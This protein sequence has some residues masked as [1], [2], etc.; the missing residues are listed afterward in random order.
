MNATEEDE[1]RAATL[2]GPSPYRLA[3][4]WGECDPFQIVFSPNYF[5]WF[6]EAT[7]HFFASAGLDRDALRRRHGF[8][9]FPLVK[10]GI[11]FHAPCAAGDR[12]A[13]HSEIVRWGESSFELCHRVLK[14]DG[15]LASEGRE[16]RVWTVS[17]SDGPPISGRIPDEV[18]ARL[19]GSRGER[20]S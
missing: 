11:E 16:T 18:I 6:D 3:V 8:A 5:V 4:R 14:T 12:L 15:R 2:G 19:G 10:A 20:K 9:G 1:R 7:W 13:I 17:A